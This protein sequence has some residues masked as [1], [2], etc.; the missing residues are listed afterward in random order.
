MALANLKRATPARIIAEDREPDHR[1]A[2]SIGVSRRT[3]ENWKKRRWRVAHTFR[4]VECMRFLDVPQ[5]L[6]NRN[7]ALPA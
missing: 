1:I 3:I 6:T 7:Y 5:S 4:F 2:E